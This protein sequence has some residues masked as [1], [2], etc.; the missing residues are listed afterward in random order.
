MCQGKGGGI[1]RPEGGQVGRG[2][3]PCGGRRGRQG[4]LRVTGTGRG[5]G[6]LCVR[7]GWRVRHLEDL[8]WGRGGVSG[9]GRGGWGGHLAE[10]LGGG[11]GVGELRLGAAQPAQL[12]EVGQLHHPPD[13][14]LPPH[15]SGTEEAAS[16][17]Q[18]ARMLQRGAEPIRPPH[19][20]R[21]G[22][23]GFSASSLKASTRGGTGPNLPDTHLPEASG[24]ARH[25]RMHSKIRA[26]TH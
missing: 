11:A 22:H 13:A 9:Q 6:C 8:G 21:H 2:G 24:H 4:C 3:A 17:T 15:T 23:K 18:G 1:P 12:A 16:L 26:R 19:T 5:A 25:A 10:D 20:S 14:H 7:D